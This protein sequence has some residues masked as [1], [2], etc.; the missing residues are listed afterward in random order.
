MNYPMTESKFYMWRAAVALIHVDGEVS[1]EETAWIR[2]H[3]AKI[4]FS[5][6]QWEILICDMEKP[7]RL[8]DL[9]PHIH[10]AKDRA[11][12]LHFA[13]ILFR[14]DGL[15]TIEESTLKKLEQKILESIDMMGT[16]KSLEAHN[17]K[18]ELHQIEEKKKRKGLFKSLIYYYEK[19]L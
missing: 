17:A 9:I 7:V 14:K 13:H 16:L 5:E 6:C 15:V 10:D 8:D 12:L 3:L 18:L 4:P 19:R 2:S 11:S 1:S